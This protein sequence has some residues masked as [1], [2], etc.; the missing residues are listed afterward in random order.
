MIE[1]VSI[2]Y[3]L[4]QLTSEINLVDVDF[5]LTLRPH[6][7][8]MNHGSLFTVYLISELDFIPLHWMKSSS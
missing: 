8:N 7:L 2:I 4:K 3:A 6:T 5:L 1:N